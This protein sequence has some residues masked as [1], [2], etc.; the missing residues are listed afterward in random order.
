MVQLPES[1]VAIQK[2]INQGVYPIIHFS[3]IFAAL[4]EHQTWQHQERRS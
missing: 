3:T 1:A 2:F 4:K